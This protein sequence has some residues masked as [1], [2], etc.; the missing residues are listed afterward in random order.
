MTDGTEIKA[1]RY[2]SIPLEGTPRAAGADAERPGI[3]L[4]HL[5]SI[6]ITLFT[7]DLA[8][9]DELESAIQAHRAAAVIEREM[10]L[11]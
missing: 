7:D 3:V 1:A 5:G 4:G 10:A 8:Y 11:R 6:P 2:A 9:L